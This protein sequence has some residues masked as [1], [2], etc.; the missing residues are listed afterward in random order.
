MYERGFYF[1]CVL[2]RFHF[3]TACCCDEFI[4]LV[5]CYD[6]YILALEMSLSVSVYIVCLCVAFYLLVFYLLNLSYFSCTSYVQHILIRVLYRFACVCAL[7]YLLIVYILYNASLFDSWE[8]CVV[9]NCL[10]LGV[11]DPFRTVS[12]S[13]TAT[14]VVENCVCTYM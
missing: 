11:R 9:F 13:M 3:R 2:R 10:L 12:T 5:I 1:V 4:R 6:V 8:V 7:I 14:L